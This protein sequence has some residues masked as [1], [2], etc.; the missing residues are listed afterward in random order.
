MHNCKSLVRN[1]VF[2]P[3]ML[4]IR[5][6]SITVGRLYLQLVRVVAVFH[7]R[8]RRRRTATVL[9]Y[10]R[11][12]AMRI[13]QGTLTLSNVYASGQR[14]SDQMIFAVSLASPNIAFVAFAFSLLLR[15]QV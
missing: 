13:R 15:W 1:F 9:V 5:R 10:S 14:F 3:A 8:R 11:A 4:R 2:H 12:L 7:R 6:L